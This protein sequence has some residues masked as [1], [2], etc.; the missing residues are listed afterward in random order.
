MS[1]HIKLLVALVLAALLLL[2]VIAFSCCC[3]EVLPGRLDD[4]ETEL[5]YQSLSEDSQGMI[6]KD[7]SSKETGDLVFS[8]DLLCWITIDGSLTYPVMK[9]SDD[10]SFYLDHRPDGK[11]SASGSLFVRGNGYQTDNIIVY[12]HNMRNGK[13]FGI[14]KKFKNRNWAEEH[15]MVMITDKQG[16]HR[17]EVFAVVV[18]SISDRKLKWE[19]YI[20]MNEE[21]AEQYGIIASKLS[22]VDL[23]NNKSEISASRYLT[24]VTCDYSVPEGRLVVIA[25][26]V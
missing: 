2:G 23:G 11:R 15:R 24:L 22:V 21:K 18:E 5:Y 7:G 17:Y 9:A 10:G 4:I 16:I 19:K 26:E 25:R 13:M 6:I 12:G 8:D 20:G 1:K 14:L 3:V